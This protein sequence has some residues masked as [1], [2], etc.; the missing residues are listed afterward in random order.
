MNSNTP[1]TYIDLFA[2]AGGLSEG[3]IRAGFLPVAHVEMDK[4]ACDTLKTRIAYHY[5]CKANKQNIYYTYLKNEITRDELWDFVPTELMQTVINEEISNKTI[6]RI[7]NKIDDLKGSEKIDVVIGG[8]PCQAYSLAVRKR[9]RGRKKYDKRKLL[10]ILYGRF[11][12]EFKPKCFIFENVPGIYTSDNGKYYRNMKKYFKRLGYEM[13]DKVMD[14]SDFGVVQRRKRVIVIGWKKTIKDFTYPDFTKISNKWKVKDIFSDLP[15]LNPGDNLRTAK[16][17]QKRVNNYLS[18]FEI[19]NGINFVTHNTVR[20]LNKKDSK[21]YKYAIK[22]ININSVLKYNELPEKM[23]TIKNT[24]DFTDRFKVVVDKN[25]SHTIIAHIAKDGHHYIHP[26][27]EQL[28]SISVREAA[29]IQSFP[30][31]F[32]FEGSRTSILKQIGNAVPPIMSK[33]IA[34]KLLENITNNG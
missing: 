20:P 7:F 17:T 22:K 21:I 19:R 24:E 23:R 26:D 10:Y 32:F 25:L 27:L 1:L 4:D 13:D 16:Y 3:F 18:K 15:K 30:D 14:A 6:E 34:N 28:R 12:N 5:L 29:R 8:P 31:D 11:L 9:K 2:G 33:N